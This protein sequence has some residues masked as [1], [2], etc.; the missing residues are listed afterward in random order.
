[1]STMTHQKK[2]YESAYREAEAGQFKCQ[3]SREAK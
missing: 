3:Q 2:M 1:M